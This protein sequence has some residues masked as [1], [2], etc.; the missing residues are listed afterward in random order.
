MKRNH[1]IL[2]L[3]AALLPLTLAPAPLAAADDKKA[4]QA[5]LVGGLQDLRQ[6]SGKLVKMAEKAA[7]ATVSLMGGH[8]AGSG[9]VVSSDG[10]ILSAA[11][12]VS[13][14]G[15]EVTVLFPD[16]KRAKAKPLGADFD[17]DAAMLKIT[18][19]GEYPH[20]EIADEAPLQINQWC[21]ALGHPG[22]FDPMRTPPLRLGRVLL[23]SQFL[24][25]DCA[26]VGGDSGGPLFDAA[27]RVVGIHSN[28]GLTLSQN[29]H[30][31]IAVF[32]DQWDDMIAGKRH[33]KRFDTKAKAPQLAAVD[34]DSPV[35]GVQLGSED[36]SPVTVTGVMDDSPAAKAGLKAGDVI[37]KLNGKPVNSRDKF[38]ETVRKLKAG[39]RVKLVYQ[40]GDET[41]NTRTK[42]ARY[43]D[44][45][46]DAPAPDKKPGG[47]EKDKPKGKKKPDAPKDNA[48]AK[49]LERALKN[50][51][52][53]ELTPD[54]LENLGGLDELMKQLQSKAG[55]LDP[56]MLGK[57]MQ[58]MGLAAAGPDE[59]FLS[60]M[61]A[62]EP[63]AKKTAGSTVEVLADDKPVA[64]G[65]AVSKDGWILTKDTETREG[66]VSVRAG[67]IIIDATLVRRFPQRDLALFKIDAGDFRPVQWKTSAD[68]PPLGSILTVTDADDKPAG[69]GL[70]SVKT[71]ALGQIG[72]LGV[73]LADADAGVRAEQVVKDGP[74]AKAGL[75]TGDVITKLDGTPAA[76]TIDFAQTIRSRKVG[77][78][79]HLDLLRD[80]KKQSIDVKL[81]QRPQP[82]MP[83]RFKKMNQMSGPMSEKTAGFPQALQ[84][85]IPID[86]SQC[87]GPL[88]DLD[89]R[90][91]GVN[92]SRAGRVKTL[93]I[94]ASEVTE[95]LAQVRNEAAAKPAKQDTPDAGISPAELEEI[96]ATLLQIK[97]S[98]ETIEQRLNEAEAR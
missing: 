95:L 41:R 78:S 96:S 91:V 74:A 34:P 4:E 49:L 3:G 22:G 6:L 16:G 29:R 86:P 30:V 36:D 79:V 5:P 98:L 67:D 90:C 89:G 77:E 65:T 84:H 11:H 14:L 64:F 81:G 8:G 94:P 75:Q 85:D 9:V 62:L 56:E 42:L 15:D 46:K 50:Q 82:K 80:G 33:G 47:K 19:P 23:N 45:F 58:G 53:L 18:D 92:V 59:F 97:K 31:P 20:V 72:F 88:L 60:S 1:W 54:D 24:I 25:T 39:R 32:H 73:Q 87:G 10:L 44:I 38:I 69:I 83:D 93:A 2:A 28:I 13:A 57:L 17:R 26:V 37:T 35:L 12:V 55:S 43:G 7:P 76:S 66:K 48:A 61:K 68:D 71:R 40:R 21:V 51:G 27:G 52:R 70:V 63:V